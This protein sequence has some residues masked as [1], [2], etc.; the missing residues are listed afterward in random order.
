MNFCQFEMKMWLASLA[1]LNETFFCNLKHCVDIHDL[2]QFFT[3][4][5]SQPHPK[6]LHLENSGLTFLI[7]TLAMKGSFCWHMKL[8]EASLCFSQSVFI[9]AGSQ[10]QIRISPLHFHREKWALILQPNFLCLKC[11]NFSL[12]MPSQLVGVGYLLIS[13]FPIFSWVIVISWV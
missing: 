12:S 7:D 11:L 5:L 3:F 4:M 1:I 6:K 8:E 2:Q 10:G 13:H 9:I